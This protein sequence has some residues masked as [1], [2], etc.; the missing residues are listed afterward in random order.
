[1][2]ISTFGNAQNKFLPRKMMNYYPL[3]GFGFSFVLNLFRK[4]FEHMIKKKC[5]E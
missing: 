2:I 5:Y 1:M 3:M 4:K